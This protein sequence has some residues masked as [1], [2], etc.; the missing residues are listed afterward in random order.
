MQ[1]H[2]RPFRALMDTGLLLEL[3][4]DRSM[5]L[6]CLWDS[7]ASFLTLVEDRPGSKH[8]CGWKPRIVW[9]L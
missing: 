1:L 2:G 9:S 4:L 7:K 6:A 8:T 3:R 5:I